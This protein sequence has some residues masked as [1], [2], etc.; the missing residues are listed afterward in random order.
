MA[1]RLPEIGAVACAIE[2]VKGTPES[3]TAALAAIEVEDPEITTTTEHYERDPVGPTFDKPPSVPGP[4]MCEF[5]FR[6][7]WAGA[8]AAGTAPM[9]ANILRSCGLSENINGGV[10]VQYRLVS[11]VSS[12]ET[13][14]FGFYKDGKLT[15]VA[16]A[17]CNAVLEVNHGDKPMIAFTGRGIFVSETDAPLPT[18]IPYVEVGPPAALGATLTWKSVSLIG[19]QVTLDMGNDVQLRPSMGAATG[20]EHAVIVKRDP[21]VTLDPEDE[22]VAT[23]DFVTHMRSITSGVAELLVSWGSVAGNTIQLNA[24]KC[25]LTAAPPGERSGLELRNLTLKPRRATVFGDDHFD[26]TYL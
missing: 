7:P 18:S 15:T 10:S 14:T 6:V 13:V 5:S 11:V 24:R 25:Q 1:A 16:G 8:L 21:T 3:L 22:L 20:Y 19:T 26:L 4:T 12:Q 17:M 9:Y 23:L 2:G